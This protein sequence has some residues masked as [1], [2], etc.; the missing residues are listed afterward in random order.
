MIGR[1]FPPIYGSGKVMLDGIRDGFTEQPG[2][3]EELLVGPQAVDFGVQLVLLD[4]LEIQVG[5]QL[6][7]PYETGGTVGC[8]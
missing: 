2:V 1:V 6:E 5:V 4:E 8:L 3:L 7:G